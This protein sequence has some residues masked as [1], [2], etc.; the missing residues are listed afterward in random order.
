MH[1]IV[2]IHKNK[3]LIKFQEI[4]I[5]QTRSVQVIFNGSNFITGEIEIR[6]YFVIYN[7]NINNCGFY[8]NNIG[9]PII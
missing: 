1:Y 5:L 9:M 4:K 8:L 2:L 3:S 7:N 6:V